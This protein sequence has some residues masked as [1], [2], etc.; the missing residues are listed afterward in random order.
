MIVDI[1]LPRVAQVGGNIKGRVPEDSPLWLSRSAAQLAGAG[2][3]AG[4]TDTLRRSLSLNSNFTT[5]STRAK[6]VSSLARRTFLPGWN[7]VP[8]W[9]RMMLPA[10]TF[11]PPNFL[12]PRYC[13]LL[14]RPFLLE[15]TP[16][17]CAM[18]ASADLHV[19]NLHFG[20]LLA[21]AG[22][23]AVVLAALELEDVDLLFLAVAHDLAD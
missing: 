12:T 17:L 16:F 5:P 13:G 23:L 21:V 20:E 11:S 6:S 19:G 14:V 18:T 10:I 3:A 1:A 22:L 9:R 15:P 4:Y 8:R 7:L 2:S